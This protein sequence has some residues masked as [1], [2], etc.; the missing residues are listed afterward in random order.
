MADRRRGILLG[1]SAYVMWGLFPLYWPLLKPAGALEILAHRITWSFALIVLVV[2]VRRRWAW[3]GA[4]LADRRRL[5]LIMVA[6]VAIALNW[7]VYIWGVNAG[8]VVETSL[9]YFI[10]PLVTVCLGVV[11]LGERLRRMQWVAVGLAVLAV[12]VMTVGTGRPP[13]I[14]LVLAFSFA[15]YGLVKKQIG[16]PAVES[17]AGETTFLLLPALALLVGLQLHGTA[18]FGHA[19]WHVSVLL[20][21]CGLVTAI[22]LLLFGAAAPLL[23]LTT[24]GLLQYVTPIMQFLLGVLVFGETMQPARWAGFVLVWGALVVFSADQLRNGLAVRESAREAAALV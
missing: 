19:P 4:L 9:G 22:P 15:T 16:M 14:G 11:L 12:V 18:T 3:V 5:L 23:P 10:N 17:L 1:L 13:W 7:G 20:G 2:V 6:S 24:I 21:L 8:Y